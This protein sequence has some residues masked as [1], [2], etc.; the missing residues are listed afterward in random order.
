MC[1]GRGREGEREDS[2]DGIGV[3]MTMVFVLG[4][5]KS[6]QTVINRDDRRSVLESLGSI[7]EEKRVGEQE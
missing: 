5:G 6:H 7:L 4:A 3:R 1:G 2:A